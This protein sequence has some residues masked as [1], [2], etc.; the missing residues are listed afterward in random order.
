MNI[1]GALFACVVFL[2][3]AIGWDGGKQRPQNII[4]I[5]WDG[6]QREHVKECL[7]QGKLPNLQ[8]LI[9]R[10]ALVDIEIKHTTDTKAGWVQILTGYNPEITGVYSN[11]KYGP[12]PPGLTVFERMEEHFGKHS[13]YTA[14]IIGKKGNIDAEGPVR[15]REEKIRS[16]KRLRKLKASAQAVVEDGLPYY[17][18]PAKPYY[19]AKN[20]V[21]VFRNGLK[22]D[23]AV[24]AATLELLQ[25]CKNRR[26]FFFVHFAEVD[27]S[28]HQFGENSPEYTKALISADTWTGA[29]VRK[30]RELGIDEKTLIYVTA[31]HGFDEGER[32]HR[33]APYV[34]LGTNDSTVVRNGERVDIAPTIL[35]RF[36]IGLE[37]LQ[38]RLNGTP[39]TER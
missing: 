37:K 1:R 25:T 21:D 12:V 39:L 26:F 4:L 5:G 18:I 20:S 22:R 32:R 16:E 17:V 31:D 27:H 8:R 36:G 10:G 9:S 13:I 15:V 14:A 24:G 35:S 23:E 34:F 38:P 6:A 30:L 11:S 33:N 29:I 28:G 2:V 3:S 7:R 19:H